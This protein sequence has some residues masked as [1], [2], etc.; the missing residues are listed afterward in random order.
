M[1]EQKKKDFF[2]SHS[3]IDKEYAEWIAWTLEEAGYSTLIDS[4]DFP[5]GKSFVKCMQE[6][7]VCSERIVI[8]ASPDYWKADFTQAEWEYFYKLDPKSENQAI[9]I[10]KIKT[11]TVDAVLSTRINTGLID[12][13]EEG[14]AKHKLLNGLPGDIQKINSQ[15]RNPPKSKPPFPPAQLKKSS[16]NHIC[17]KKF[18]YRL[19]NL[20]Q[21]DQ[22][23]HF[24]EHVPWEVCLSNGKTQGFIVAGPQQ[25]LPEIIVFTLSHIL[26]EW[27][28][29]ECVGETPEITKLTSGNWKMYEKRPEEFLWKRFKLTTDIQNV[30]SLEDRKHQIKA[31]LETKTTCQIFY[32]EIQSDESRNQQFLLDMLMA[33]AGLDL[34]EDSPSHFLLLI[35]ETDSIGDEQE[36]TLWKQKLKVL[37]EHNDRHQAMLPPQTSPTIHEDLRNWMKLWDID[38]AYRERIIARFAGKANMPFLQL[39]NELCAILKDYPFD[40]N[41]NHE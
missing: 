11:C 20:N 8:V 36:S 19:G 10:V 31:V 30:K 34:Q 29:D 37:L 15:Q 9:I 3:S 35:C 13:T 41:L 27:M 14:E 1:E 5:S 4:W 2:I 21:I 7:L 39:K 32:R 18:L 23:N 6:G 17:D 38:L 24:I 22:R 26:S 16:Q 25:E 28:A 33:W 12:S 40:G